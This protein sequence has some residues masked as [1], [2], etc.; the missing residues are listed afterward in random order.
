MKMQQ[1]GKAQIIVAIITAGAT[2][3]AA[4]I[5]GAFVLKEIEAEKIRTVLAQR[6]A[7]I[8]ELVQHTTEL[9]Q[10]LQRLFV[11]NRPSGLE[12]EVVSE[13]QANL[14]KQMNIVDNLARTLDDR[15]SLAQ[16]KN[17]KNQL[18]V[19]SDYAGGV[20][21]L[22]PGELAP[23]HNAVGKLYDERTQLLSHVSPK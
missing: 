15:E 23:M 18:A 16:V 1:S 2:V 10:N 11:E 3:I 13:V 20:K 4:I 8:S 6:D 17:Y 12:R 22:D 14:I 9:D 19:V 5:S 7:I 21:K